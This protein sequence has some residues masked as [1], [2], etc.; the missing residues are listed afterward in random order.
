MI[1]CGRQPVRDDL[2][3]LRGAH[4]AMRHRNQFDQ[5]LFAGRGQCLHVAVQHCCEGLLGLPFRMHRRHRLHAIEREGQLHIH[6]LLDPER[7]VIVE[8]RDALVDR[9]EVRTALR[10]DTRDKVEDRRFRRAVVPGGKRIALCLSLRRDRAKRGREQRKHR[11]RREQG[12]AINAEESS[13]H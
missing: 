6:W 9:Y 12:A 11:Q 8:G 7:A 13:R 2:L 5:S 1:A 4:A 3:E 10:R